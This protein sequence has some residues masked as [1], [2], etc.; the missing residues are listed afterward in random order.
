M[1]LSLKALVNKVLLNV[2]TNSE[3]IKNIKESG[4]AFQQYTGNAHVSSGG[5]F[6]F[7]VTITS[8][9]RPIYVAAHCTWNADANGGWSEIYISKNGTALSQATMVST[10]ASHNVP[11]SVQWLDTAAAGTHT[12]TCT[13]IGTGG[14]GH[15]AENNGSRP[16]N[17]TL[18]A[19][20]I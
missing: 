18:V 1:F 11:G 9:G 17:P 20:E 2:K 19:F 16:E 15:F 5:S 12:Y 14:A 6:S 3:D 7:S 13:C 8:H 10:T 4:Y